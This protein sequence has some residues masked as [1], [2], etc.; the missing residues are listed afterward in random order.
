MKFLKVKD[1]KFLN[2]QVTTDKIKKVK[3]DR[4]VHVFQT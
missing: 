3:K 2:A 1:D 4:I